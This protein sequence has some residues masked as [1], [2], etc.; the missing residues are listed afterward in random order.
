MNRQTLSTM[1]GRF[2]EQE[3]ALLHREIG[4]LRAT[5]RQRVR[6]GRVFVTFALAVLLALVPA[7]LLAAGFTDLNPGS[8]HN[9][10]INAI[11]AAGITRGCNP[12]DYDQ[13]CPND[14][15]TRE[16]MASF[17]ARTAGLG[18][19]P[20]VAHALTAQGVASGAA[21]AGQVLT[22]DGSG[23]SAFQA[24]PAGTGGTP[25]PP[26]PP[27]P[28]GLTYA[29]T[30][31]VSPVGP[32]AQNGAALLGA[33]A[34][35][36]TAS[37]TNPWLLKLEPGVYDLGAGALAMKE[38]VDIEGAGEGVTTV[39]AAGVQRTGG[40][41]RGAAHAELRFLTV[42]NTGSGGLNARA[43]VAEADTGTAETFRLTHVTLTAAGGTYGNGLTVFG[44]ARLSESTIAASGQT[45]AHGVAVFGGGRATIANSVV[46]AGTAAAGGD[47]GADGL[48]VQAG[49]TATVLYST[50]RATTATLSYGISLYGGT[51]TVFASTIE[52][53]LHGLYGDPNA[54]GG[55]ATIRAS[56]IAGGVGGNGYGTAIAGTSNLRARVETSR[57][58]GG[59]GATPDCQ[60][61]FSYNA[62]FARLNDATC[63]P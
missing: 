10:N 42:A 27:G 54:G 18:G 45:L 62:F 1:L 7:V 2:D 41:V 6:P 36:T 19:N 57:L 53:D 48:T 61:V 56:S 25:G 8:P 43:V 23:G 34:G 13:Y 59:I 12:P 32:A 40:T 9:D 30:V 4:R 51:V 14:L 11:A 28:S 24:L 20:P 60:S 3:L 63:I 29:R 58:A 39:T 35:I 49:S 26:G 17:L 46:R 44:S 52:S 33:L 15:V 38:Y 22:A 50:V 21:P 31:L 37:A 16:Q 55:Q 5:H 47:T